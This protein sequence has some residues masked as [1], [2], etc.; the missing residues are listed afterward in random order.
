MTL[1]EDRSLKFIEENKSK[2]E[3]I[4]FVDGAS[5]SHHKCSG[6]GVA[7]FH[8]A[9][10]VDSIS[11]KLMSI[12]NDNGQGCRIQ[13]N[14]EAE[15]KSTIVALEYCL[16]HDITNV[17]I[18]GDSKL[19]VKQVLG[20]WKIK[21]DHLIPLHSIAVKLALQVKT[22]AEKVGGKILI[23]HVHREFNFFADYYSK[24][25]I[26]QLSKRAIVNFDAKYTRESQI[27]KS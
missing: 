14:N 5:N 19:V 27:F 17:C 22:N 18:Y 8:N 10:L 9:K 11:E 25:C 4:I 16:S 23:R 3:W 26:D 13:T 20:E 15:Y 12:A 7:I 24:L 2:A 6:I 1:N 21:K